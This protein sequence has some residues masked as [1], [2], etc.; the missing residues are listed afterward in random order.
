METLVQSF[1]FMVLWDVMLCSDVVGV[2][3]FV[4]FINS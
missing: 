1:Q 3:L 4:V 2:Q